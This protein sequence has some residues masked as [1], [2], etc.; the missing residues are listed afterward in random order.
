VDVKEPYWIVGYS[1]RSGASIDAFYETVLILCTDSSKKLEFLQYTTDNLQIVPG[2]VGRSS[3]RSLEID[4]AL[5][6]TNVTDFPYM[7]GIGT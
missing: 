3:N 2:S 4:V 1:M 7:S 5:C 6:P